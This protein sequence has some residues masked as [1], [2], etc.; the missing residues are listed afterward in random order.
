MKDLSTY[1]KRFFLL[2][3]GILVM[4]VLSYHLSIK[5]T[6]YAAREHKEL[7]D[8]KQQIAN[9]DYD[10]RKWNELNKSMDTKF[11]G[12][13]AYLDFQENLL[14]EVGEFCHSN[15]LILS[16][17]SEPFTGVDGGYEVE[18]INL[19]IQGKFHPLLK[20]LH[21]LE[22]NFKGGKISSAEF[23]KEKNFKT[24]KEELFL[25]LY[26]QKINKKDDEKEIN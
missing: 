22:S 25:K 20:L 6:L 7:L 12:Y 14:H 19:K 13:G 15:K 1:Q 9:L 10:M 21:H 18:T 8:K 23:I 24:N 5:K 4:V 11:G 17:F 2:M 26:V 16:E 3:L